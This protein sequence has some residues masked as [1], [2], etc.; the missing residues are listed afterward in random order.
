MYATVQPAQQYH[1]QQPP[2]P[3][4]QQQQQ[5][6]QQQ[7]NRQ[8]SY[9]DSV[10]SVASSSASR[11]SPVPSL[12]NNYQ[13]KLPVLP[14][15]QQQQLQQPDDKVSH[16]TASIASSSRRSSDRF[17]PPP[18]PNLETLDLS[19]AGEPLKPRSTTSMSTRS[20]AYADIN[21]V[22]RNLRV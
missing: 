22:N 1:L 11:K 10:R 6:Q 12:T 3:P 20:S 16:H 14:A 7:Y 15:Q 4:Q 17:P 8:G 18:P 19:G 2:T 9:A 21:E 5:Q 13:S